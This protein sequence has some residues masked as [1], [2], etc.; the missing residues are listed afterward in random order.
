MTKDR[1]MPSDL[2][3][4]C[5]PTSQAMMTPSLMMRVLRSLS[6]EQIDLNGIVVV[7]GVAANQ[8]L[9]RYDNLIVCNNVLSYLYYL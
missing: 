4:R 5:H 9:R 8:E 3:A 1:V 2:I 6:N 7:G